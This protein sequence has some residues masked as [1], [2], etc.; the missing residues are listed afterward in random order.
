ME[1][2]S[3]FMLNISRW[4]L[5]FLAAWLLWRC[6]RSMLSQRYRPEIWAYIEGGHGEIQPIYHW[7]C[8]IGRAKSC[9]VVVDSPDI[10][11]THATLIRSGKGRWKL[12]D[13]FG[14]ICLTSSDSITRFYFIFREDEYR[15]DGRN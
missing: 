2:L 9:D 11:R 14:Q 1:A 10:S 8:I 3:L 4:A 13:L 6:V 15:W 12:Y 5:P 7:E